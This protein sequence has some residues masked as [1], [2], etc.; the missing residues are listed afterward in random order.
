MVTDKGPGIWKVNVSSGKSV[1]LNEAPSLISEWSPDGTMIA[2]VQSDDIW[3]V[4]LQ[5]NAL[6]QVTTSG[7][8]NGFITW[9]LDS[10]G[11]FAFYGEEENMGKW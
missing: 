6:K 5:T 1:L 10:T 3:I 7:K 8:F 11:I 4:D 9:D 2:F